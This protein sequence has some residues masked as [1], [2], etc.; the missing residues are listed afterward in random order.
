MS[1]VYRTDDTPPT[2]RVDRWEQLIGDALL[3]LRGRHDGREFRARLTTGRIGA[4]RVAEATTPAGQCFRSARMIDAASEALYQVDVISRGEV[5]LA[6]SDRRARLSAGDLALVDPARPVSYASSATTHVS[7]LFPRALVPLR[8]GDLAR[9]TAVRV[10]GD[11]GAGAL[12]SS[13]ARQLP[14][15]LDDCDTAEA[16]RLGTAMV[17]LLALALS[18]HLDRDSGTHKEPHHRALLQQVYAF[19]DEHLGAATLSPADV[20][21]AHHVSLR[22]LYTLFQAER[23]TVAGWIRQRRLDR[24]RRDLLDPNQRDRPV[25]AIAARWGLPNPAHFSRIFKAAYGLTP[26]EYRTIGP[27]LPT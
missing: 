6:Q 18:S 19:I 21:A 2:S 23:A 9:L 5:V 8:P 15:H 7:V 4:V 1:V 27:D 24:C 14:R 17:D 11:Y 20:A 16:A 26:A 25:S 10:P 22:Y 3:P 13:L 12:V